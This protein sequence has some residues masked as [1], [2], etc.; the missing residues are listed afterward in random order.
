M[1][2]KNF[3]LQI[4]LASC[5]QIPYGYAQWEEK[6]YLLCLVLCYSRSVSVIWLRRVQF[7]IRKNAMLSL[8]VQFYL[9]IY[10]CLSRVGITYPLT[11]V[12]LPSLAE[13]QLR[14]IHYL[15]LHTLICEK[16]YKFSN[17]KVESSPSLE[18]LPK[19]LHLPNDY[20]VWIL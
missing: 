18:I 19:W 17:I 4:G 15:K 16:V 14:S 12:M 1:P 13:W 6:N 20:T 2:M 9:S 11:T 3:N 5:F 7:Q 10:S 8:L